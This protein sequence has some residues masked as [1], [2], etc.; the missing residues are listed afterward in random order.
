MIDT[1][2]L[3]PDCGR[4]KTTGSFDWL[5]AHGSLCGAHIFGAQPPLI[6]E[7]AKLT[8][9]RLRERLSLSEG[10]E[11]SR[12]LLADD[13]VAL[14]EGKPVKTLLAEAVRVNFRNTIRMGNKAAYNAGYDEGFKDCDGGLRT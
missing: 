13:L 10:V 6:L 9:V 4:E 7:C 3:C 12:N 8:I 1:R 11:K 2:E 5:D 14:A